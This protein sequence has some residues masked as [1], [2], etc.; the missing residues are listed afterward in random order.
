MPTPVA[1]G[2]PAPTRLTPDEIE[3]LVE[4]ALGEDYVRAHRPRGKPSP[5]PQRIESVARVIHNGLRGEDVQ[6]EV[7]LGSSPSATLRWPNPENPNEPRIL[8]VT[9]SPS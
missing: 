7:T 1:Q 8:K 5:M 9:Y 4:G 3:I 2:N 6:I